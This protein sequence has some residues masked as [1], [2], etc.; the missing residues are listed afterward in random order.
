[1]LDLFSSEHPLLELAQA[2]LVDEGFEVRTVVLS[3][4]RESVVVAEDEYSFV[5][6]VA[7]DRWEELSGRLSAIDIGLANW[8][9]EHGA[10][11][12]R[13]D[14]YLACLVQERLADPDEF[15][16]AERFE[17]DTARVRK[18]VR[19]GVLPEPGVLQKALAPFLRLRPATGQAAVDPL[20]ALEEKLRGRGID[21]DSAHLAVESFIKTGK[22]RLPV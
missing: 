19:A 4:A 15:A 17:A 2:I 20:R 16:E 3:D 11:S 7:A 9:A 12:K 14:V 13:W 6:L 1:L 18:Y 21:S 5:A 8:V 10:G 22:V